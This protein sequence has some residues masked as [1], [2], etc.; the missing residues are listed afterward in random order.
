LLKA[1]SSMTNN[2]APSAVSETR[3]T[4]TWSIETGLSSAGVRLDG[5]RRGV[6]SVELISRFARALATRISRRAPNLA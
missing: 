2:T 3:F 6:S 5:E 1:V 4:F